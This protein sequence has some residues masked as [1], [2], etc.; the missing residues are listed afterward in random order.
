M[1]NNLLFVLRTLNNP[2]QITMIKSLRFLVAAAVIMVFASSC[3]KDASSVSIITGHKWTLTSDVQTFS[4]SG[5][6]SHN[7][8]QTSTTCPTTTIVEFND[9]INNSTSRTFNAYT[10]F[11][12]TSGCYNAAMPTITTGTWDIDRDNANFSY[13]GS[14]STITTL[15][16]STMVLTNIQY[17][18]MAGYVGNAY[19]YHDVTETKTLTA[20]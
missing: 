2:K 7:M 14:W 15:N 11:T 17:H 12:A 9:Y 19:V 16:A 1:V 6:V 5:T 20:Q 4:D 10:S 13:N 8:I 18:V 3:K